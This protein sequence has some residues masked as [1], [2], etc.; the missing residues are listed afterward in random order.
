MCWAKSALPDLPLS[1][2][3]QQINTHHITIYVPPWILRPCEGPASLYVM[4][5][6]VA[7]T[8]NRCRQV[9][10]LCILRPLKSQ[11]SPLS[12][13]NKSH[14]VFICHVV[15]IFMKFFSHQIS[16]FFLSNHSGAE[17]TGERCVGRGHSVAELRASWVSQCFRLCSLSL[18]VH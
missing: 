18:I 14:S 2:P 10:H 8:A 11:F 9:V 3:G 1:Q 7:K 13:S 15:L 17:I 6:F 12:K 16:R 5:I 4:L